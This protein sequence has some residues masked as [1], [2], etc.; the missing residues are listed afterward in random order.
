MPR[1]FPHLF[2]HD[3]R[4]AVAAEQDRAEQSLA[5]CR[6]DDPA[7][8]WMQ[9]SKAANDVAIRCGI[10]HD[11]W[12]FFNTGY[13]TS[14]PGQL[15]RQAHAL[16]ISA[17][18][19]LA[20]LPV[21][22]YNHVMDDKDKPTNNI[23]GDKPFYV[24]EP[25]WQ[26]V[27]AIV[28]GLIVYIILTSIL[29]GAEKNQDAIMVDFGLFFLS[30]IFAWLF[31]FGQFV[32]PVRNLSERI[33]VFSRLARYLFGEHGPV[34]TIRNGEILEWETHTKERGPGIVLLD[35]A[36]AAMLRTDVKYTRPVGPGVAFTRYSPWDRSFEYLASAADLRRHSNSFGPN[37][38]PVEDPFAAI[39]KT[40]SEASYG[41]RQKRRE[42]TS[43]LTRD[44]IEIVP[45]LFVSFQL[46]CEPG[47]GYTSFGYD[48]KIVER[49]LTA[50]AIEPGLSPED[51]R[52]RVP[53]N[54]LPGVPG[55]GH[56]ARDPA[57]VR[58]R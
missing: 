21:F 2:W 37:L 41:E 25:K 43:A 51:E 44:G 19:R 23:D 22:I 33:G 30:G 40:E 16:I 39:G 7:Q 45:S 4:H 28:F 57:H 3:Q 12:Y 56:L 31:F 6:D 49:A 55:G 18:D 38:W 36:S 20:S 10:F 17:P 48:G 5:I 32:L 1:R 47:Q 35:T 11:Q 29:G 34:T 53:W 14:K 24:R 50:E 9:L 46:N 54:K 15:D 27:F 52:Y 8:C 26:I 58:S 42:A 13:F